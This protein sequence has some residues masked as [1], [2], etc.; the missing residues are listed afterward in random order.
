M[1]S[2]D[3]CDEFLDAYLTCYIEYDY[4]KD[5]KL[6]T[7][8]VRADFI[9]VCKSYGKIFNNI[10]V[11]K[12]FSAIVKIASLYKCEKCKDGVNNAIKGARLKPNRNEIEI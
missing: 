10:D 3:T 11:T 8:D 6:T 9:K 1:L 12:I 7:K 4:T 2:K 5:I